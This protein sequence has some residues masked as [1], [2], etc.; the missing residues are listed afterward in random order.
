MRLRN[1]K[2]AI[3][4]AVFLL[5]YA[6]SLGQAGKGFKYQFADVQ[7]CDVQTGNQSFILTYSIA[8]LNIENITNSN[9]TFYRIS[10]PG[11][12][13]TVVPG[14]P[15]LP[16]FSRLISIP[17]GSE[18]KVKIS[19][20]RS[21][22]ITPK[23]KDIQGILFPVQEGETKQ[24]TEKKPAFYI[25]K[26]AYAS[27]GII[28]SDTVRIEL[29]GTLRNKKLANIY[30]SPVRY[31][32]HSNILE[33]ITSMKIEI[34][35]SD[36]GKSVSKS[37]FSE[38]AL[39]NET[40][41]KGLLDYNP[42]NVV[43]GY[44][45]NPV[46]MVIVTDTAFRKQLEP[47]IRWKTQKGIKINVLY[48][49]AGFA[50]NTY[51]KLKDALTTI[52][53]SSSAGDPPPEYLLIIG[54][55]NKVPVYGTGSTGNIT[56]MYY[57]EFD[58]NGDYIPD[59][60]IGR[61]PVAD[62][63]E[64]KTVVQK[65]IQYEK[66][67]YADSNKFYSNALLT[68]GYDENYGTYMNGQIKYATT[69]YLTPAN[70]I[71]EQYYNYFYIKEKKD[72]DILLE[73]RKD[74]IIKSINKGTSF[75]N[76]TGHGV[77]TGWQHINIDTST[78]RAFTNKNMYPF[79][80]SNACRTSQFNSASSFGNAMVLSRDKGAIGFIGCSNDSYW[81]E[82][83]YWA[84]GSGIPSANPTY[85]NKG[86]GAYDRLFHTHKE[87]PSDWYFTM[88][89]INY[90]G[91]LAVSS[92]TS[93][94]KKYYWET[95]NLVGDPSVIPIL[96]TP[97]SFKITLP[98]T[99]PNGIKTLSVNADPFSYVAVSHFD[100]LWD[101]SFVSPSGSAML[102]MP[103]LSNDS[104]LIVITGQ[105]KIPLIKTLYI[106]AL[107]NEFINLTA[108]GI[109]DSTG[110]N[111]KIADYGE[112]FFLKLTVSNL[113]LTDARNLYAKISS[114]S[115]WVTISKDSV[116]IGTLAAGSNIV[117]SDDLG[118]KISD[119]IPDMQIVTINLTLKD[120][121]SEK[122]FTIDIA[123]HAPKLQIISCIMDDSVLG[124][125]NH[126]ADPGETF[127]LIFKVRNQG[128]SNIS[129]QFN[130]VS[131]Q[132]EI[133]ITEPSVK[134][135]VL[136]FGEIT[137]IPISVKL[138]ESA[139]SGSYFSI[140]STLDCSPFLVNKEFTFRV[141]KIRESF[142]SSSFNIFPWM[143]LSPVPWILINT[144]SYDGGIS[145][146][147][148]AISHNGTTSLVIRTVYSVADSLKFFYK[149]SSEEGYD[150]FSFKLNDTE[151][152][153]K[154][155]EISWTRKVVAV[156]AG[157]NKM[158]WIYKKDNSVSSGS[159]CAWIDMI[160]FAGSGSVSYIQ[161]DLQVAKVTVPVQSEGYGQETVSVKVLNTGKDTIN[162]FNLAYTL[163]NHFPV[164]QFFEKKLIPNGDSVT[165]SFK[166]KADLS[167]Y[168]IYN[169][170][171][172]GFDNKDDYILNDT[173][174]ISVENTDINESFSIYPNP[175][176]D[177]FTIFMDSR[178]DEDI[179]ISIINITGTTAYHFDKRIL[180]GKNEITISDIRLSPS[181][182]Y[183]NIR[184]TTFNKTLPVL[185]VT[186]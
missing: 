60:Y 39:F 141:G 113:G 179:Q 164:Q 77:A 158:E 110:N 47:F 107:K 94:L 32:P 8:E 79:V 72:R 119:N 111:N 75:I 23:K 117:L 53:R 138:S 59:M 185:K 18:C 33:V 142:E 22:R 43:P 4:L 45:N 104:C 84:V 61:L 91:N 163:N 28:S 143:N 155:G 170:V 186:K 82:D 157:L 156:P 67:Q 152:F 87:S 63:A 7:K 70:K 165:I 3:C 58:G 122:H 65:I 36:T 154:S 55:V 57:G 37:L 13:S 135:G 100:T 146:R 69:N 166:N 98:D 181:S 71:K 109:N 114:S 103:G 97:D 112:S 178:I 168:G 56:D 139:L 48:F 29:I 83:F 118:I 85:L 81:D 171:A 20:V 88:G 6:S 54:D 106:S 127:Q 2:H 44:S 86:L 38:S 128:S 131:P 149:V 132:H 133:T 182:Y 123:V 176:T 52:Y 120:M 90:A 78:V 162:G 137:D 147:S 62:T 161:K 21:S 177:H 76:Y 145:A 73:F 11:H 144:S 169:I 183:I 64:L 175:F 126:L 24:I 108:T 41:D 99:I 101:A 12:V 174:R 19:E 89:Q 49:G 167:K 14:E 68:A 40:L 150:Y 50:G 130:I 172:Y 27:T 121:K 51:T 26:T 159:D 16:V 160:D 25:D 74:S 140:S 92:S 35:F 115:D 9:G 95:Y 125:D 124:N 30:I 148:G 105:N 173:A 116:Q 31:D 153:R 129:G 96:G 80:V 180:S 5:W 1:D 34:T 134:S 42:G 66:F 46:K 93:S 15:E 17:E 136:K 102:E 151:I 10:I 184:G